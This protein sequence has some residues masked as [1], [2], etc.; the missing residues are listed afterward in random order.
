MFYIHSPYKSGQDRF[1]PWPV[2]IYEGDIFYFHSL[3]AGFYLWKAAQD[4]LSIPLS[5]SPQN[6][7]RDSAD[8]ADMKLLT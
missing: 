8:D 4:E 3:Q 6:F 1:F 5:G 2:I 7:D